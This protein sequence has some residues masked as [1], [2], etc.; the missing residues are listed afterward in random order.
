MV[1]YMTAFMKVL[2]VPIS[3]LVIFIVQLKIIRTLHSHTSLIMF[4]GKQIEEI[5][6]MLAGGPQ[7]RRALEISPDEQG[8]YEVLKE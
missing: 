5:R 6:K 2:M 7:H 8:L 1:Q 4:Y 3:F